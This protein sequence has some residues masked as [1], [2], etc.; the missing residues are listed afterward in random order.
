M[1]WIALVLCIFGGGCQSA[2]PPR[3]V[4]LDASLATI[5]PI[6]VKSHIV[7]RIER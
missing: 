4:A 3:L 5:T 2:P 1:R 6:V 7:L